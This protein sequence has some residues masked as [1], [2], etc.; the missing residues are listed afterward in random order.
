MEHFVT[1]QTSVTTD[2]KTGEDLAAHVV[3]DTVNLVGVT[4]GMGPLFAHTAEEARE[5]REKDYDEQGIPV[6]PLTTY[7]VT[8][9]KV[10]G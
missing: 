10:E 1:M 2:P 3:T 4:T 8:F 7:R 5:L 9:E 6:P